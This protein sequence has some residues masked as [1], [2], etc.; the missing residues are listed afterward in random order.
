MIKLRNLLFIVI[1]SILTYA[2]SGKKKD[3]FTPFDHEAQAL[4]D[5]DTIL[6]FLAN[7]YYDEV[8]LII[9][10]L[11]TGK[12][13]LINDTKNLKSQEIKEYGIN[14]TMYY[15]IQ[16]T[17]IDSSKKGFPTVVDSIL[18]TYDVDYFI[19]SKK[20]S[21]GQKTKL[22]RWFDS[23]S[24]KARGWVYAFTHL[25]SGTKKVVPGEPVKFVGGG[26]GIFIMPS[27]L[28]YRN[29]NRVGKANAN[30]VYYVNLWDF[31]KDTDHDLDG[32]PSIKEDLDGD[33]DPR[34]DDTDGD[35][36]PNFIDIDDDNDR[37]PT[38]KEDR[39][40]DGDPT[41]DFN[42]PKKPTLPD[43]LNPDIIG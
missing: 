16:K 11:V 2:C 18:A 14:Y 5:K 8:D 31:T 29:S 40:K 7:H 15:I 21:T 39:N 42:D 36:I 10:P 17:G 9:K 25:K 24:I 13:A 1:I 43:Y 26:K 38:K 35:R 12:T 19:D 37:V 22:G 30:L 34:N 23:R 28:G 6:K 33:G 41:N 32:I 3:T 20:I 4:K 27:G